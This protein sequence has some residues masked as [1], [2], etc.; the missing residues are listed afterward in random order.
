MAERL[1]ESQIEEVRVRHSLVSLVARRVKLRRTGR[2]FNGLC[3]FHQE[4]SPSFSVS[5]ERGYYHCFGCGAHGDLFRWVQEVEGL[6]FREAVTSLAGGQ[7][8]DARHALPEASRRESAKRPGEVQFVSSST[9]G[10][11]IWQSAQPARGEIV[12][13]YLE[14]RGL[15][16]HAIFDGATPAISHLRFH[17]RCPVSVW[18]AWEHPEDSRLTAPA[19]VAP[20]RDA[21][22]LVRGVHVTFL[23]HDGR[24]KANLGRTGDG[25]DR[26]TRKMFGKVGGNGVFLA[27]LDGARD[28][29]VPFVVGEG[30]ETVWAFADRFGKPC[31]PI[32]TL[33]LE[34]LQ[35]GAV[36]LRDGSLP[37]WKVEADPDRAPFVVPDAGEAL[38]LVDA[39]MKPLRGMK[40]QLAKGE[41]PVRADLNGLQRAEICAALAVQHWRRAGAAQVS[42]VRPR[43]GMDFNDQLRGRVA[44]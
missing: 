1:T 6:S 5:D 38:I 8:P 21:E 40:V 20:I 31:V 34:N 32:A 42:A 27:P 39:D 43:L 7:L 10:R 25:R 14:S 41:K 9:A 29:R 37:L 22:G 13:A 16:P 2:G 35:G 28:E 30:I 12:E 4:K 36:K 18:R 44:A 11:W 3:P 19:M 23:A 26:P 33:S 15:N 17:P 24:G